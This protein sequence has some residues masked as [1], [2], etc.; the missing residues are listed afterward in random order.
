MLLENRRDNWG[1]QGGIHMHGARYVALC[2]P[3]P[4][5]LHVHCVLGI[6]TWGV[7]GDPAATWV[8][9]IHMGTHH[10]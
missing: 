5:P 3:A 7:G 1:I 10:H 8:L 4:T 9:Y 6:G 2:N